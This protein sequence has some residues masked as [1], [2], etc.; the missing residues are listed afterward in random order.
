M[1]PKRFILNYPIL[2]EFVTRW[3]VGSFCRHWKTC[4]R[5]TSERMSDEAFTLRQHFTAILCEKN[6]V[7]KV[8]RKR[9]ILR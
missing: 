3:H 9:A 8:T 1:S 5:V 6:R 4:E 7:L 2:A